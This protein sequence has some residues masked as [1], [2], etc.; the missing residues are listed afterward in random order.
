MEYSIYTLPNAI[1]CYID[2]LFVGDIIKVE[3]GAEGN[4]IYVVFLGY[5]YDVELNKTIICGMRIDIKT[6]KV[7]E[8]NWTAAS[9]SSYKDAQTTLVGRA[10]N[11]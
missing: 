7:I 10:L 11:L 6:G 4:Y 1:N 9:Y 8:A 5:K 2:C 3:Y